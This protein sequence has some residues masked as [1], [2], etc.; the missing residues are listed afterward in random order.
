MTWPGAHSLN[1]A[2]VGLCRQVSHHS[3]LFSDPGAVPPPSVPQVFLPAGGGAG[4]VL[5]TGL[6]GERQKWLGLWLQIPKQ[7]TKD[8]HQHPDRVR[9]PKSLF[10]S[11]KSSGPMVRL[12]IIVLDIGPG[13]VFKVRR[14]T[15]WLRFNAGFTG[16]CLPPLESLLRDPVG[17]KEV[18]NVSS[19]GHLDPYP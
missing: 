19:Q 6:L 4:T 14:G 13:N 17:M 1:R 3:E 18:M 15:G 2:E 7:V 10:G 5:V 8:E 9:L 16:T 11:L 12:G